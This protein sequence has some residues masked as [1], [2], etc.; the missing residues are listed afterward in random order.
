MVRTAATGPPKEVQ[1]YRQDRSDRT[2][3]GGPATTTWLKQTRRWLNSP[4]SFVLVV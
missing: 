2:S 1:V 4:R 3:E